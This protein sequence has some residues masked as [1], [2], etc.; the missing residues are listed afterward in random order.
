MDD[1][2][3]PTWVKISIILNVLV[4]ISTFVVGGYV[5]YTQHSTQLALTGVSST[6]Q[7]ETPQQKLG[8]A[9]QSD[10]LSSCNSLQSAKDKATCNN[11]IVFTNARKTG[12]ST[13]CKKLISTP[14]YTGNLSSLIQSCEVN[15]ITNK[16]LTQKDVSICSAQSTKAEQTTCKSS[17]YLSLALKNK[18][19]KVCDSAKDTAVK[20]T[21]HNTFLMYANGPTH[22]SIT[23]STLRGAAAQ[24]DCNTLKPVLF[25]RTTRPSQ[26]DLLK[27]C[28]TVT[29]PTFSG[30]CQTISNAPAPAK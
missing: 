15:T 22:K 28:S 5:F 1:T 16:A 2:Q 9:I 30:F 19:I 29:S 20:N 4:L 24:K 26:K 8:N 17:Y 25:N 23:C 11:A 3:T 21:C 7:A 13:Y 18:N 12:D 6:A 10:N 14:G 27:A